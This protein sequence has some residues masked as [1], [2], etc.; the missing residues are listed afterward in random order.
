MIRTLRILLEG[1]KYQSMPF[2]ILLEQTYTTSL[3][4]KRGTISSTSPF[5]IF[6]SA[7]K[8]VEQHFM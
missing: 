8:A 1:E 6:P 5:G 2:I 7:V 4:S 3:L